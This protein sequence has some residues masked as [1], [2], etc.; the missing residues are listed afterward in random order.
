VEIAAGESGDDAGP[1]ALPFTGFQLVLL[2]MLGLGAI[3]GG[4]A[5]RRAA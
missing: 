2:M 3:A 4:T 1:A 5:L